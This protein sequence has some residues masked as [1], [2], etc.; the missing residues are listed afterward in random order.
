MCAF[1]KIIG[2]KMFNELIQTVK[3]VSIILV[4]QKMCNL[5]SNLSKPEISFGFFQYI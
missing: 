3:R 4:G 5:F 1:V 2:C